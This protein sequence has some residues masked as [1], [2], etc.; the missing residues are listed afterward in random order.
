LK[1]EEKS[2]IVTRDCGCSASGL[3]CN[4][5]RRS[6]FFIQGALRRAP[7]HKGGRRSSALGIGSNNPLP[8]KANTLL[9]ER[10]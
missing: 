5:G 3:G 9:L 10:I 4:G 2:R 1:R 6:A 7:V 8:I